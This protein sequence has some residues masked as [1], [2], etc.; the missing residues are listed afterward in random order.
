M[1]LDLALEMVIG[2]GVARLFLMN[3]YR[4]ELVDEFFREEKRPWLARRARKPNYQKEPTRPL[5]ALAP[6]RPCSS[7]GPDFTA[8]EDSTPTSQAEA[9]WPGYPAPVKDHVSPE[10]TVFVYLAGHGVCRE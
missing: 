4:T 5:R 10:I 2:A 7:V 8:S 3:R 6:S 9:W 1:W